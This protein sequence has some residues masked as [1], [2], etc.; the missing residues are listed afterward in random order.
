MCKTRIACL[1]LSAVMTSA[2]ALATP[3]HASLITIGGDTSWG[4]TSQSS[5][6]TKTVAARTARVV[7]MPSRL[8]PATS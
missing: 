7:E 5:V 8:L 3:A 6:R 1:V 4:S 2:M